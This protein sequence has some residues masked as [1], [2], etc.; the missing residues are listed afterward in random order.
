M[1]LAPDL[2][3]PIRLSE[4]SLQRYVGLCD[5]E[6]SP[7]GDDASPKLQGTSELSRAHGK[8]VQIGSG[9]GHGHMAGCDGARAARTDN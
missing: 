8:G 4:A 7:D 1:L 9:K 5:F 6:G 3:G 2:G